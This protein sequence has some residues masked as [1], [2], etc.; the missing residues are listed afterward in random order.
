MKRLTVTGGGWAGQATVD[1][2][3]AAAVQDAMVEG[4]QHL[5]AAY[6]R[7]RQLAVQNT[8]LKREA[9]DPS[10]VLATAQSLLAE[11]LAKIRSGDED[12]P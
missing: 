6:T 7:A 8:A 3:V 2:A 12:V 5:R 11:E 9:M 1:A 10:T 4:R